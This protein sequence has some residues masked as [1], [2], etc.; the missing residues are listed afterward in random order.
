MSRKHSL[1]GDWNSNTVKMANSD[2]RTL[3]IEFIN[4][5]YTYA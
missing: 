1:A 5:V 4:P 3:M 2:I